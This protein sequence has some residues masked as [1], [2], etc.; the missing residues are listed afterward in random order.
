MNL[1]V[2]ICLAVVILSLLL[3]GYFGVKGKG[4]LGRALVLD[5]LGGLGLSALSL[6]SIRNDNP[7]FLDIGLLLALVGFVAALAFSYFFPSLRKLS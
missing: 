5:F 7:L 2:T 1:V 4:V 6:L 3:A